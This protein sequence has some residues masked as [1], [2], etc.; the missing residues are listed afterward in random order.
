MGGDSAATGGGPPAAVTG[1]QQQRRTG[2]CCGGNSVAGTR[3]AVEIHVSASGFHYARR[4]PETTLYQVVRDNLDTL[5][6][7]SD[8]GL[9]SPLPSFVRSELEGY[10]E[11]GL[12]YALPGFALMVYTDP[13]CRSRHLVAFSCKGRGFCPSCLGRRM[14]QTVANLVD[15]VLPEQV[16]VRQWVLTVPNRRRGRSCGSASRCSSPAVRCAS[17]GP[18]WRAM[19]DPPC[20]P[21]P[22]PAAMTRS[23]GRPWSATPCV[24]PLPRGAC[25]EPATTWSASR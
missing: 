14:A 19:G 11:C 12:P 4:R 22:S 20:T 17:L 21:P 7:V 13:D 2:G 23:G 15:H 16:P 18:F 24:R 6:A 5:H 3:L 1:S 8:A 25:R 9:A 10:L